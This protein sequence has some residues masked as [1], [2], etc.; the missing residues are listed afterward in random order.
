MITR[1]S[2]VPVT[3]L[4]LREPRLFGCID[5]HHRT[6]LHEATGC[7]GTVLAVEHRRLRAGVGHFSACCLPLLAC[8]DY[9][10]Q[11]HAHC[12]RKQGANR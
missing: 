3:F 6:R 11:V 10:V 2:G 8:G 1:F 12:E 7:D 9:R 5:E 4:P